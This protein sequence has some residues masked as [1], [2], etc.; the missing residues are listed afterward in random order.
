MNPTALALYIIPRATGHQTWF[1][2]IGPDSLH[3]ASGAFGTLHWTPPS[4]GVYAILIVNDNYNPASGTFS[5]STNNGTTA[6]PLGYATAPQEPPC[7]GPTCI[8]T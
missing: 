3:Y 4:A 7:D 8:G 6:T 5:V 2:D 1:C